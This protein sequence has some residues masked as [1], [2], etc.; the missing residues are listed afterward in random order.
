MAEG[1][2]PGGAGSHARGRGGVELKGAF[3]RASLLTTVMLGRVLIKAPHPL[4]AIGARADVANT[5][6]DVAE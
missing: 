1:Q 3:V 2:E 4:S 6:P 5:L